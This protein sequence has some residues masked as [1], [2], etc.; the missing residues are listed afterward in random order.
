VRVGR[1]VTVRPVRPVQIAGALEVVGDARVCMHC[2]RDHAERTPR[3]D[4][5]RINPNEGDPVESGTGRI[6]V[7]G[8]RGGLQPCH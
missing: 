8:W 4:L 2:V 3:L 7:D 5:F 6:V 1:V